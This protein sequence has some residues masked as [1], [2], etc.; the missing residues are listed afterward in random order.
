M[1]WGDTDIHKWGVA[2]TFSYVKWVDIKIQID[3]DIHLNGK[4]SDY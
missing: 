1:E 3:T 4:N 2:I